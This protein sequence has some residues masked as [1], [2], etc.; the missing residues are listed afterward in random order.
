MNATSRKYW[1]GDPSKKWMV[2]LKMFILYASDNYQP[3]KGINHYYTPIISNGDVVRKT[4]LVFTGDVEDKLQ[5]L[6]W[7]PGLLPWRPFRF[8]GCNYLQVNFQNSHLRPT[9][10]WT[11]VSLHRKKHRSNRCWWRMGAGIHGACIYQCMV[12]IAVTTLLNIPHLRRRLRQGNG[13]VHTVPSSTSAE[14]ISARCARCLERG[15][16]EYNSKNKK[17]QYDHKH[18]LHSHSWSKCIPCSYPLSWKKG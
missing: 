2:L 6:L 1:N 15:V 12:A 8:W 10:L 5:R 17:E 13:L 4:A 11:N 3:F 16:R 7:I 14:W 9:S 18:S